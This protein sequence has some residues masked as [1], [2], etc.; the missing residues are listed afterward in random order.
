MP[1]AMMMPSSLPVSDT[2][3][4]TFI[5]HVDRM[6]VAQPNAIAVIA[7]R[8]TRSQGRADEDADEDHR[9]SY[10]QLRARSLAMAAALDGQGLAPG[11][12]VLI[13]LD[14]TPDYLVAFLGCL[15]AGLI[16]V[17]VP[18]PQSARPQHLERFLA[19]ARDA[20]A[21]HVIGTRE[22]IDSNVFGN[23]VGMAVDALDPELRPA[24][25]TCQ[26]APGD[27]AFLQYTSGSTAAPKG[28]MVSHANLLANERAIQAA[29]KTTARDVYVSWLPPFHDM[30]LIGGL[31]QPL[32]TGGTLVLMTTA[33]FL[34]R[35]MR[36]IEAM[37]RYRGT[38]TAGPDFAYRLCAER[39]R[40]GARQAGP[41]RAD[42]PDWDL[43]PW[44]IAL[45]GAEPVRPDTVTEFQAA[46]APLGFA[47]GAIYPSYGLAE[48]TLF[49]TGGQ[50]ANGDVTRR[51]SSEALARGKAVAIDAGDPPPQAS[52]ASLAPQETPATWTRLVR[53][54][55]P[56]PEHGLRIVDPANG[57]GLP[58]ACI[59]EIQVRGPSVTRGYWGQPDASAQTFLELAPERWLRTGD[60]GFLLD[61]E[62]HV[63]GRLKDLIILRGHNLYPQD[64]EAAIEREPELARQGRVAA[65]AVPGADGDAI[66]IA[67]E[68]SRAAQQ[69]M[70]PSNLVARIAAAVGEHCGQ[71]PRL[72]VLL[73]PGG[74]PKTSS[75]KIQR[76]AAR[77][78]WLDGSLDALAIHDNGRFVI[79][80]DTQDQR[81]GESVREPSSAPPVDGQTSELKKTEQDLAVLW[82]E[83]IKFH[84][85]SA[86]LDVSGPTS[87]THFFA[88]GGNSLTAVALASRVSARWEIV[89]TLRDLFEAP[90]LG[91]LAARIAQRRAG[92]L[93]GSWAERPR[94]PM[95]ARRP[96]E[97]ASLVLSPVQQ[98]LWMVERMT[99]RLQR[100]AHPAYNMTAA[101]HLDGPLNITALRSA[102]GALLDRH[103]VLRS[104][105]PQ[106]DDGQPVA[107]VRRS[108]TLDLAVKDLTKLPAPQH[109]DA[110]DQA[111]AALEGQA[112]DLEADLLLRASMLALEA[113]RH[114]LLLCVH[115]LVFDGW[116]LAVFAR[117]LAAAYT[118]FLRSE[119]ASL[120]SADRA[121]PDW[122]PLPMQY[123]D[124][125][126][127]Q[128][129]ELEAARPALSAFWRETLRDAPTLS[130]LPPDRPR[131]AVASMAGDTVT[132]SIDPMLASAIG[133]LARS[134]GCTP[135]LVMLAAFLALM[136]QRCGQDDLVV[137][138]DVA[139]RDRPEF[140]PLIGF[141]VNVLPLRS[142]R[143]PPT[144]E[145]AR[146]ER[147]ADW[148]A[149]V[150]DLSLAA[151]EHA[152]MPFDQIV[153]AAAVPRTRR[154]GPLVQTL[155]VVQNTP[156]V[157]LHLP[158]LAARLEARPAA[159]AKFD[160]AVFVTETGGQHRADWV[161]STALYDRETVQAVARD[162]QQLLGLAAARPQAALSALLDG[163]P[164]FPARHAS[165]ARLPTPSILPEPTMTSLSSSTPDKLGKLA[166]LAAIRAPGDRTHSTAST[167]TS[168]VRL[169]TL[170][171]DR[172]FPL[173]VEAMAPDLDAVAWARAHRELIERSL[174][175]HAG[176]LLRNFGLRTP[177]EFESFAEAI[178]PELFG[179]YGDLPKK[180]GGRNTYRSTPYPERQMILFH[181]ESAHLA[182]WPRKQWFFC[183]QPSP[184]GGATPIVDGREMLRRL[185]KSIVEEFE[186]KG[187][188]YIRTFTPRLD[189]SWQDFFK[190]TVHAEVEAGLTQAGTRFRWLDAAT[191]QTRHQC[192]AVIRHPLTGERVFFNQVQLHHLSCLEPEVRADLQALVGLDRMPRHVTFG[193]GSEIPDEVMAVVG[194][195]YEACAVRLAWRQGDIIMLDNMLAAHARDPYEGPRKIV[196]AMGAMFDRAA[197]VG[198][199]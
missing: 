85:T 79:G 153:E 47:A 160:L 86:G 162:W 92:R 110:I 125:A 18:L 101:V 185:P 190:T 60:L 116:S 195:T 64:I 155:F 199:A 50:R 128:Q 158:G 98:R 68:V 94:A 81:D 139:G 121:C 55:R 73:H 70:S 3:P 56:A 88:V 130:T 67:A 103:D 177:Q 74:L 150:R 48:A 157:T 151:F 129:R 90:T 44:R 165:A 115:H 52:H 87:D 168:A 154:H 143:V 136:H 164:P 75:G 146:Q 27:I 33:S 4:L 34:A 69:S 108:V 193:D 32:F 2:T 172:P 141:F 159:G 63:T 22:D 147:L 192:P 30:G 167:F 137:G 10:G 57:S 163:L 82:R 102:L 23:L 180:E 124:Y 179:G 93:P 25:P 117:D 133:Q 51:F 6:A 105:Y 41:N 45:S 28:V 161:F 170:A 113:Q 37:H 145:S 131:P 196:V 97:P 15:Y 42:G 122:P 111:L 65:F 7:L 104:V 77:Q 142:R 127:W 166:K 1:A 16:A 58:D 106:D 66:G 120:A 109:R 134:Q 183:E 152:A 191:L 140:E 53:C 71:A 135:F 99:P 11:A 38:I 119:D 173:I 59:G 49:V 126:A 118:A 149:R 144:V 95:A 8:T 184:V 46:F 112:F 83:V 175:T 19:V 54:G 132:V 13:A 189:V 187:L 178:E 96:G 17:P 72:T 5:E 181:N 40:R 21:A 100:E 198:E 39:L 78:G 188:L 123:A 84:G 107:Q 14:G 76:S 35:P 36:W 12:R 29:L 156:D 26:A 89:L 176:L 197:L 138:T 43:R 61:G 80:G 31:L 171:A 148:L 24:A 186:R 114:V 182:R 20:G 174:L 62:L 194:A 169:S 91:E 9:L